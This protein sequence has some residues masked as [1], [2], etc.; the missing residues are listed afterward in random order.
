MTIFLTCLGVAAGLVVLF[1]IFLMWF[2]SGVDLGDDDQ[3]D[4]IGVTK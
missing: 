1:T 4:N 2:V 3:E